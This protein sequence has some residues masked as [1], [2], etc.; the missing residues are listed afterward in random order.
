[1]MYQYSYFIRLFFVLIE[2]VFE[3][4]IQRELNIEGKVYK[5]KVFVKNI[6]N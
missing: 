6:S 2:Y 3:S 5:E 1:M 4:N